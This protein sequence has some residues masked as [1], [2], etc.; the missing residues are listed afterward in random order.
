MV[1]GGLLL[2]GAPRTALTD[3]AAAARAT[4]SLALV[5]FS[6][7]TVVPCR[8][9]TMSLLPASILF[10]PHSPAV[11]PEFGGG[12]GYRPRVRKAYST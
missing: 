2:P 4:L 8:A 11:I 9:Q 12:A 1:S 10:R 7:I 6:P 5:R 3:Y